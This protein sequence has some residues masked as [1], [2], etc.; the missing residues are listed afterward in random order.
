MN[1][2]HDCSDDLLSECLDPNFVD[3]APPWYDGDLMQT[4]VAVDC[5]RC[6]Y[7]LWKKEQS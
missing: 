1:E 7:C 3:T 2:N 6:S 5:G 4:E